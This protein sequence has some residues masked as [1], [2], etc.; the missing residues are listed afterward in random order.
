MRKK[1]CLQL[2]ESINGTKSLI[3]FGNTISIISITIYSN[4]SVHDI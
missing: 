1:K 4:R 3:L 2:G